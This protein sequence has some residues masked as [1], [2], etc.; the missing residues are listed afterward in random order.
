MK[1]ETDKVWIVEIQINGR[2]K[3]TTGCALS[4]NDG[5]KYEL[6]DWEYDNLTKKFRIQRYVREVKDGKS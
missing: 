4:K 2:W 6:P 5:I 1:V 3:P